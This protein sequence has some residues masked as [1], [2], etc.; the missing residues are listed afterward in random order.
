MSNAGYTVGNCGHCHEQHDSVGED[1][2]ANIYLGFGQEEQ[3]CFGCHGNGGAGIAPKNIETDVVKNYGHGFIEDN[4]SV[5]HKAQ[6]NQAGIAADKHV[7]CTDCHNPHKAGPTIHTPAADTVTTELTSASPLY[8]AKGVVPDYDTV[9]TNWTAPS[10]YTNLQ[11]ATKDYQ[12]CFKCH[13][14]AVD[15][16]G[17]ANDHDAP[18]IWSATSGLGSQEWTDVGLEF[19]PNNKSGHPIVTG[20]NNYDNSYSGPN[21]RNANQIKKGLV[22]G[23]LSAPWN[24]AGKIGEQTMY[25]SDCHTSNSTAVGPHGSSY[26][27]MLGGTNK[28][29]P[30]RTAANN[31]ANLQDSWTR[32]YGDARYLYDKDKFRTLEVVLEN[33]GTDD[34]LFCLNCHPIRDGWRN[35]VHGNGNHYNARCADCH[36]RVPHGGKVSRLIAAIG[37]PVGNGIE[38][39]TQGEMPLRYTANGEGMASVSRLL[40][41][42]YY[43]P[44]DVMIREYTKSS[45][46]D[47]FPDRCYSTNYF[48]PRN[49][50]TKACI[51]KHNNGGSVDMPS[52]MGFTAPNLHPESW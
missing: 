34:G 19:S 33:D 24:D 9:T 44:D 23:Q 29:W 39:F 25:C 18:A 20:L 35:N 11:Q 4:L 37:G 52:N 16:D 41:D 26:K 17:F 2:E 32:P 42:D 46:T 40:T 31:G 49:Y 10:S 13:S 12:I 28:A 47:Y 5:L 14:A 30:Y 45:P 50:S 48:D 38:S 15:G 7:E 51:E 43:N 8:G 22:T 36:I 21:G 27:W 1:T 3:L 6:E